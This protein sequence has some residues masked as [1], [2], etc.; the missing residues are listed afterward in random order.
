MPPYNRCR[1]APAILGKLCTNRRVACIRGR[2][3]SAALHILAMATAMAAVCALPP[4]P[5][6]GARLPLDSCKVSLGAPFS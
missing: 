5:I 2:G 4:I 1:L 3:R 6:R